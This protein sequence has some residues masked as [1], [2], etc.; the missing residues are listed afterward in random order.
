MP[1]ESNP[2]YQRTFDRLNKVN[3][4]IDNGG[5]KDEIQG[6]LNPGHQE[7]NSGLSDKELVIQELGNLLAIVYTNAQMDIEDSIQIPPISHQIIQK[8]EEIAQH[9]DIDL[10]SIPKVKYSQ[11][12]NLLL[13]N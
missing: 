9:Y 5:S 11:I 1:Q 8:V 2:F 13:G 4:L 6:A 7:N 12:K 3:S 10:D